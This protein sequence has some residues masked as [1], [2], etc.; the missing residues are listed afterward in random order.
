MDEGRFTKRRIT[1]TGKGIW[2]CA[3]GAH[4]D[5]DM[6]ATER[7]IGPGSKSIGESLKNAADG[8]EVEER[9]DYR[10][11]VPIA[12]YVAA[13]RQDTQHTSAVPMRTLDAPTVL[14][15]L[16]LLRLGSN[17]KS[18]SVLELQFEGGR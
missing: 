2:W 1:Y 14:Q 17:L 13:D 7:L 9:A 15:R 6:Q 3:D 11:I 16:Q 8:L 18:L 12:R 5:S 4:V 10:T